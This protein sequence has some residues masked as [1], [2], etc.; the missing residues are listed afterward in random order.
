VDLATFR[1]L[2][3]P[4]GQRALQEATGDQPEEQDFLR[5]YSRLSRAYPAEL[6]RAALEIAILRR[7][8]MEKFPL[9]ERMYFTRPAL[10]QA[11]HHA[12]A[13]YRSRRF[14]GFEW[15]IDL[16]C[17]IGG[18]T[19]ALAQLAPTL[20]IDLDALRLAM[21]RENLAAAGLEER[22]RFVQADL[23]APLP[24]QPGGNIGVFFDPARRGAER[25]VFSTLDYQPPL[26]IIEAWLA[27]FPALGVKISPGVKLEELVTYPA[28]IEFI[29]YQGELKEAALW[30]GPL[31]SAARRATVLPAGRTLAQAEADSAPARLSEPRAFLYEPDPAVSRAGLVRMLA[32]QIDACQ[33]DADIAY[34]TGDQRIETPFARVWAVDAW[35]PFNLKRL[36]EALRQRG[37]ER[38][39]VKKRGSP[40]Q[41]QELI[42]WLRLPRRAGASAVER[43]LFLTHLLGQ[44]VVILCFP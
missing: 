24:L 4:L 18:D 19:L 1:Q 35:L 28:E 36:R 2:I 5:L 41:P 40:I 3:S 14:A 15:L 23:Q 31:K 26:S 43:V 12:V 39:T 6:A 27:R 44:P 33:L 16:G 32:E 13:A 25:R 8:A 29:S 21:A 22:A 7:Q 20:G 17:S 38:V 10:E 30:F 34:L 11:T 42:R 37:V 9:A